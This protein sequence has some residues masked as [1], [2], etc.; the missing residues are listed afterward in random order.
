MGIRF[1]LITLFI[2]GL[3]LSGTPLAESQ[4]LQNVKGVDVVQAVN[5]VFKAIHDD[6]VGRGQQKELW[7]AYSDDNFQTRDGWPVVV[8]GV[9]V[10]GGA[11]AVAKEQA[12]A[13]FELTAEPLGALEGARESAELRFWHFPALD[14]GLVLR[15]KDPDILLDIEEVVEDHLSALRD[16]QQSI[17]PFQLKLT[18]PAR[19]YRK[20][21]TIR[22]D[23]E[24]T[25]RSEHG[26]RVRDLKVSTLD[27]RING[28]PWSEHAGEE[29][30]WVTL[31]A[32]ESLRSSYVISGFDPKEGI[33]HA[34]CRYL[35]GYRD[36]LPEADLRLPVR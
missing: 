15:L 20:D 6:L 23:F 14:L 11:E 19:F 32:G 22:L 28:K 5:E 24:L 34:N 36:I 21:G 10:N 9:R 31:P 13:W 17:L 35:V 16:Y 4:D 30:Q 12:D 27:C 2:S 26:F 29:A 25:N 18:S 7:A 3:L 1:P 33:F 8:Y